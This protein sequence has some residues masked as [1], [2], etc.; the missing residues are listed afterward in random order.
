MTGLSVLRNRMNDLLDTSFTDSLLEEMDRSF[1]RLFKANGLAT[2]YPKVDVYDKDN[3]LVFEAAI[4]GL[5]KDQVSVEWANGYLTITGEKVERVE[6]AKYHYH[7]LKRS[8]FS[9]TF[10]LPQKFYDVEKID[11]SVENGILH[12]LVPRLGEVK[13]ENTKKIEVK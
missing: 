2:N 10:S 12:V 4:P 1:D 6:D 3:T 11:A 9:R 7:E 13:K 8:K 5:T